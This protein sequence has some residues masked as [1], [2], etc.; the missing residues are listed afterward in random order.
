[1]ANS[2]TLKS[3]KIKKYFQSTNILAAIPHSWLDLKVVELTR[4]SPSG[5][6]EFPHF[7]KLLILATKHL[8]ITIDGLCDYLLQEQHHQQGSSGYSTKEEGKEGSGNG[9]GREEGSTLGIFL[10]I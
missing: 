4:N 10:Q 6:I 2:K 1:M 9:K 8:N 5:K 7:L 3:I